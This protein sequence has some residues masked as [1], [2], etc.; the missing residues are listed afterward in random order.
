MTTSTTF[1]H[2]GSSY[3]LTLIPAP[4]DKNGK[5]RLDIAVTKDGETYKPTIKGFRKIKVGYRVQLAVFHYNSKSITMELMGELKKLD[6]IQQE[7]SVRRSSMHK[8]A[9]EL[10]REHIVA[11]LSEDETSHL[12]EQLRNAVTGFLDWYVPNTR[13]RHPN[14]QNAFGE[15]LKCI[16]SELYITPYHYEQRELLTQWLGATDR[17]YADDVVAYRL[18]ALVFREF[19][20]LCH[21]NGVQDVYSRLNE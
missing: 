4:L 12:P 11:N 3:K 8:D 1:N 10:I 13:K 5:K 19:N 21:L 9:K 7:E 16:P 2:N 18:Y 17:N 14:V 20:K 15:W 6:P